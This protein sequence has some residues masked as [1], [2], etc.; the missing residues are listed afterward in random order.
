MASLLYAIN[1]NSGQTQSNINKIPIIPD[2]PAN[3]YILIKF[4]EKA[5]CNNTV[6]ALF[7]ND[8]TSCE[9]SSIN[10]R[11]ADISD[12]VNGVVNFTRLGKYTADVYYQESDSNLDISLAVKSFTT[13]LDITPSNCSESESSS[14]DC[15]DLQNCQVII[16]IEDA[17]EDLQE[18]DL[19]SPTTT[20]VGD[21]LAGTD[22]TGMSAFEILQAALVSYQ[23]PSFTS[24]SISGVSSPIEVG[25]TLSGAKTFSWGTTNPSNVET[26]SIEIEDVTGSSVLAIG[27][28]NDGSESVNIGTIDTSSAGTQKFR[29]TGTNTETNDFTR[30]L[31]LTKLYPWFWGV[32]S[33]GGAASGANRPTANQA[34]IDSG[35]KVVASSSGTISVNFNSTSDDYLWF[36]IPTTSGLESAWYINALNNGSIG[37]AVSAGGNLFPDPDTVNIATAN[38]A[39]VNYYIY[40]SNY[41]TAVTSSMS[42]S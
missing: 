38:W 31:N 21:L 42:L 1:N 19:S 29:I 16:D 5:N 30:D 23:E 11:I 18:Y 22:I 17:I 27:L 36:A 41:Q 20:T 12:L 4:T 40:I 2:S 26:N 3:D 33:S 24:L 7:S 39:G 34:L 14:F 37:G 13:Y 32:E 25:S 28:A 10:I 8:N 6:T 15:D 9:I 35:T